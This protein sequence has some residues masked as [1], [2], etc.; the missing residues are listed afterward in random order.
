MKK[1]A[2]QQPEAL[3]LSDEELTLATGGQTVGP[4]LGPQQGPYFGE[5][6]DYPRRPIGPNPIH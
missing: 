2:A 5:T 4:V 6:F 1:Q 3:T